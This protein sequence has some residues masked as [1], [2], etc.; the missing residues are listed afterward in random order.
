VANRFATCRSKAVTPQVLIF[1]NY[2]WCLLWNWSFYNPCYCPL[3][4]LAVW[5][6]WVFWMWP[7]MI[8]IFHFLNFLLDCSSVTMWAACIIQEL[9]FIMTMAFH[10]GSYQESILHNQIRIQLFFSVSCTISVQVCQ[11]IWKYQSCLSQRTPKAKV[12]KST[13]FI[14]GVIE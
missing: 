2:L 12:R 3:Y 8:C 14:L 7:F 6:G 4:F 5:G 13:K 9:F 11:G 1:V 10:I